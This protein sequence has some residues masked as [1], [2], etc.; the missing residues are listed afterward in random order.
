MTIIVDDYISVEFDEFLDEFIDDK[1]DLAVTC[2]KIVRWWMED[3]SFEELLE[4]FDVDPAA[5]FFAVVRSGL[6]NEDEL[7]EYLTDLNG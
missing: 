3:Y 5:A 4:E 2:E 7:P 1:L 6:I